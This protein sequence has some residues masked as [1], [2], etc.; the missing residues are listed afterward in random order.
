MGDD[1][2]DYKC[3]TR[4]KT[5]D[6]LK[7]CRKIKPEFIK[8][9]TL[10][11]FHRWLET[12]RD[13]MGKEAET[14]FA[15]K[16]FLGVHQNIYNEHAKTY[17]TDRQLKV[18]RINDIIDSKSRLKCSMFDKDGATM[19]KYCGEK[20]KHRINPRKTVEPTCT[21]SAL[22][23]AV[24]NEV[25]VKYCKDYPKEL[26]CSCYNMQTGVC[27]V[28]KS[29]AGCSM[30]KLDPALA[31]EAALGKAGYD[32]LTK[33]AQC[34][35]GTCDGEVLK[36]K[37]PKC[38]KTM[39]ICGK[40]WPVGSTRNNQLIRYCVIDAGGTEEDVE[41]WGD[42][43]TLGE[44]KKITDALKPKKDKKLIARRQKDV[45]YIGVSVSSLLCCL[46]MIAVGMARR[47]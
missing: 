18:Q 26:W 28:D 34:R 40:D 8:A 47:S 4:P 9:Q 23:K 43:P 37:D 31:D 1:S 22:G 36:V 32:T 5:I 15:K 12:S 3:T 41:S 13:E 25:A 6:H 2:E 45:Q 21:Q 11:V 20:G 16:M 14:D 46:M 42:V 30:A 7:V 10:K 17:C 33:L 35:F 29:A 44:T 24:F 27:D 39:K 38:P 19:K